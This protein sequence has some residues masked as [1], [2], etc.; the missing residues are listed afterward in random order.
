MFAAMVFPI[1][2]RGAEYPQAPL[3]PLHP[4]L[5]RAR[6]H[7]PGTEEKK[8]EASEHSDRRPSHPSTAF[9]HSLSHPLYITPSGILH[10]DVGTLLAGPSD[11]DATTHFRILPS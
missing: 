5:T 1:A 10:L 9:L 8:E 7:P 4:L 6:A 2:Y 3:L 11:Q